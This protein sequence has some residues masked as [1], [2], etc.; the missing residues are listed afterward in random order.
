MDLSLSRCQ[1][2]EFRAKTNSMY[3]AT[4]GC[5]FHEPDDCKQNK[6]FPNGEGG[7]DSRAC[8][9]LPLSVTVTKQMSEE[10]I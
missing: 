6:A 1:T 9:W 3:K 7:R 2:R 4:G 8:V 10:Q 5:I